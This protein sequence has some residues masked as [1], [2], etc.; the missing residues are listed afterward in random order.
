MS[1]EET[2]KRRRLTSSSIEQDSFVENA[3]KFKDNIKAVEG[4]KV[5]EDDA[6]RELFYLVNSKI[7]GYSYEYRYINGIYHP[8]LEEEIQEYVE[9]DDEENFKYN[10]KQY[11]DSPKLRSAAN[12]EEGNEFHLDTNEQ[13]EEHY[14]VMS[15]KYSSW[16]DDL[17]EDVTEWFP[18]EEEL[19]DLL[20]DVSSWNSIGHS[21]SIYDNVP[22]NDNISFY[23]PNKREDQQT[24]MMVGDG[25]AYF[26][27]PSFDME[28][29]I[30]TINKTDSENF[31]FGKII[32]SLS[33][34]SR[35][36]FFPVFTVG[37]INEGNAISTSFDIGDPI[38]DII[39]NE[40]VN[41]LEKVYRE[42]LRYL[43]N[44][45]DKNEAENI[46][47]KNSLE[48]SLL[49]IDKYKNDVIFLS[50][51][52]I[53][54]KA[55][56]L[57]LFINRTSYIISQL[58]MNEDL[59]EKLRKIIDRRLS[60]RVGTLREIMKMNDRTNEIFKIADRKKEESDLTKEFLISV[61]CQ[62][63]G[64]NR[65]RI[66]ILPLD[67]ILFSVDDKVFLLSDNKEVPEIEAEI[68]M[69]ID[70]II[71]DFRDLSMLEPNAETK[72]IPIKKIFLKNAYKNGKFQKR[73]KIGPEYSIAEGLRLIKYNM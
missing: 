8:A 20:E 68:D 67:S 60:K 25:E 66:F 31:S 42:T 38:N 61:R 58:S 10:T 14:P 54:I 6:N 40:C 21:T 48:D 35:I 51:M 17:D 63:D 37:E 41:N 53:N 26:S 2:E 28:G 50:E 73:L 46:V 12:L 27:D 69:I 71:P 9:Q 24:Y 34:P 49:E 70:G 45:P 23:D 57:P 30:C 19:L 55:I 56:R 18:R 62:L 4:E 64:D 44:N 32:K 52:V 72:Y 36:L 22:I 15:R 47:I 13:T 5:K 16:L 59:Y 33:V 43:E 29:V 39:I 65:R 1:S 7:T 3:E 11:Y